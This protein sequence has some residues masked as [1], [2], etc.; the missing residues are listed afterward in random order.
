MLFFWHT[1]LTYDMGQDG[2]RCRLF[3]QSNNP[4][5]RKLVQGEQD[6]CSGEQGYAIIKQRKIHISKGI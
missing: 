3:N 2:Q 4:S 5:K 6:I 1:D